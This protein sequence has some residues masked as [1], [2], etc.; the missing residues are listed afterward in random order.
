MYNSTITDASHE[1]SRCGFYAPLK[2]IWDYLMFPCELKKADCIV[3]F[4]NY[5]CDIG[6]RAA[7]LWKLGYSEHILFSGGL[8]RNTLGMQTDTEAERF[9]AAAIA[10]GVPEDVILIENR[11]TNTAEN[12]NFTREL[13]RKNGIDAKRIIGVHQPFMER[14]I[15][16]AFGVYWKECELLTTSPQVDIETFFRHTVGYGMTERMVIEEVV[17]DFQRMEL[18]AAKGW[19]IPQEITPEANEAFETLVK[20]GYTG[21]L[22]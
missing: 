10:E 6:K 4:G 13:L 16:A 11:S 8:G 20:L 3:G 2:V 22:A 19:Q 5:N 1:I 18:Y 9:A 21:Q 14:R 7:E 15:M 12:I 17:G